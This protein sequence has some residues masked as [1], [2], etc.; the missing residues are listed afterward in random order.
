MTMINMNIQNLD[1][2]GRREMISWYTEKV[3]Q[4]QFQVLKMRRGLA[5]REAQEQKW[6][7]DL[8]MYLQRKAEGEAALLVMSESNPYF[9][10]IKLDVQKCEIRLMELEIRL[11]RFTLVQKAEKIT[12]IMAL[13]ASLNYYQGLIADSENIIPAQKSQN[14]AHLLVD[15]PLHFED[16]CSESLLKVLEPFLIR[17]S[18]NSDFPATLRLPAW[19]ERLSEESLFLHKNP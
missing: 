9:H 3:G 8:A 4:L 2:K 10:K 13:E 16:F 15:R 12:K 17:Y 5:K 7:E 18:P 6:R 11:Q 19:S 14:I 1:R